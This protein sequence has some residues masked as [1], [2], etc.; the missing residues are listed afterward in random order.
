M[1]L[2]ARNCQML[3]TPTTI[4]FGDNFPNTVLFHVQLISEHLNC[5]PTIASHQLPY[6][7]NAVLLVEDL[8]FLESSF[9]FSLNHLCHSKTH[10]HNMVLS[11]YNCWS[12]SNAC[13]WVFLNSTK[14]W[15]LFIPQCSKTNNL[16]KRWCKQKHVGEKMQ[17]LQKAKI[18]YILLR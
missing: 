4:I 13:G 11:S 17:W 1:F 10:V 9:I 16:K 14:I 3:N 7:L 2:L 6:L 15:N 8:L 5:Q 18:S 12:I